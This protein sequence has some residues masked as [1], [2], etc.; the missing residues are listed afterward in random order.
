MKAVV[1]GV[2]RLIFYIGFIGG[3]IAL[4]IHEIFFKANP[5][6]KAAAQVAGVLVVY[7]IAIVGTQA[8]QA[9]YMRHTYERDYADIIKDAFNDNKKAYKKLMKGIDC[10]NKNNYRR[11]IGI[12]ERLQRDCST[13]NEYVAVRFF[14][15]TCYLEC[16]FYDEA[17]SIYEDILQR[18]SIFTFAWT[19][20]GNAYLEAGKLNRAVEV[21]KRAIDL[22]PDEAVNY[23]N[24][25]A[26]YM[27]QGK[28][29]LA[30]EYAEKAIEHNANQL[31]AISTA[32]VAY[33]VMGDWE[34]VEK[35]RNMYSMC[36]G[37]MEEITL[38]LEQVVEANRNSS[39]R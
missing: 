13:A 39:E 26:T 8:K 28:P 10:Y 9:K 16:E 6:Y 12:L 35:Y 31:E 33:K 29:E 38:D 34:N 14:E 32:A 7:M 15:A 2:L 4:V 37:D 1:V 19:N 23:T 30:V 20:L 27:R 25:A 24:L 3:G 5:D 22:E 17:I 21:I 36:G 11:A 18:N